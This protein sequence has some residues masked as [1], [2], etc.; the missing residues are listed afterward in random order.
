LDPI[1]KY[2]YFV[3]DDNTWNISDAIGSTN[4]CVY[5]KMKV[6]DVREVTKPWRELKQGGGF[7]KNT[8]INFEEAN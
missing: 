8:A 1:H 2:L 5:V 6:Y 3:T 7:S 4:V